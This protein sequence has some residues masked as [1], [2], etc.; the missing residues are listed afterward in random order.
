MANKSNLRSGFNVLTQSGLNWLVEKYDI[1]P[2]LNPVLLKKNTPVYPFTP[3]K[4]PLYTRVFAYCNYRI[5]FTWF[6]I[7]VLMFHQVHL[8][9]MNPFGLAKVSHF[10]SS[11]RALGSNP[12]LDVFR[13]LYKLNQTRDWYTF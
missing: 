3:G 11:C 12:D 10:E 1:P 9:E 13:A 6:L 4:I 7:D 2:A 5:P 8:S